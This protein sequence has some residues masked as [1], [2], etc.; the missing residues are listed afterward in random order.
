MVI[1]QNNDESDSSSAN[2]DD[3]DVDMENEDKE[4]SIKDNEQAEH[5]TASVSNT[6][7]HADNNALGQ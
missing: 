7:S 2:F 5:K 3:D 6:I 4:K 1:P